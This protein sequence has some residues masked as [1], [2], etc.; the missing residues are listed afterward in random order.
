MSRGGRRCSS[1]SPRSRAIS[2]ASNRAA[3][4]C[5]KSTKSCN[6][7][8]RATGDAC[9]RM[10]EAIM[11]S[12]TRRRVLQGAAA[13]VVAMPFVPP[14]VH[15]AHAAGKLSVGFWDHWVPGGNDPLDKLCREWAAKEKVDI[16]VDFITSNGD[17][18]LLTAAA[19]AQARTGHDIMQLTAWYA[20]GYA[21]S[22]EPVD[23]LMGTLVR[24]NGAV[25]EGAAYL[26]KQDGHWAAVPTSFGSTLSP[27][28]ARIDLM[29]ELAG[30]D[31]TK[32]YP[33]GAP[34]DKELQDQ[35]TWDFFTEAAKKCAKGA[36]HF[37]MP[38]S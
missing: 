6:T 28:C 26:G 9:A 31:I 21:A 27:P 10:M 11:A 33:A 29:K 32:M 35:W 20:P 24:Q 3:A 7:D 18:D 23:D 12:T 30:L 36:H 15:G 22:L 4:Y 5:R 25:S 37:G 34:P 38:L 16:T 13:S 8:A 2:E 17:K 1:S 19:E 14:F